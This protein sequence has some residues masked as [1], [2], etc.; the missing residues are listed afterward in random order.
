MLINKSH[1]SP[2]QVANFSF[3]CKIFEYIQIKMKS[4]P[5]WKKEDLW[6][7]QSTPQ[8]HHKNKQEKTPKQKEHTHT[9]THTQKQHFTQ[10]ITWRGSQRSC[11]VDFFWCEMTLTG[12]SGSLF[13]Q[14]LLHSFPHSALPPHHLCQVQQVCGPLCGVKL[15]YTGG[16]LFL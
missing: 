14:S 7:C 8:I 9:H 13:L 2:W 10:S 16:S 6:G 4:W 15:C 3:A 11:F 12:C 5:K 1:L